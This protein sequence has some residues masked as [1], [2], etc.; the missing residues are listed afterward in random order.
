L[1][2][3]IRKITIN[4][5]IDDVIFKLVEKYSENCNVLAML[6][7]GSYAKGT[8]NSKSDLDLYIIQENIDDNVEFFYYL[9]FPVQ[10]QFR[11][12]ESFKEKILIHS[13]TL[14]LGC[15]AKVLFNRDEKKLDIYYYLSKSKELEKLGPKKL[16]K[17]QVEEFLICLS[18]DIVPIYGYI[19]KKDFLSARI[20]INQMI[21]KALN[22]LYDK[23]NYF[24]P[25]EKHLFE[26][27]KEKDINIYALAFDAICNHDLNFCFE[28]CKKLCEMILKEIGSK[29]DTYKIFY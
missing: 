1:E 4:P 11:N 18:N 28:N 22:L 7:I 19:E 13:R 9:N 5:Y 8:Y 25:G 10:I 6:L 12:I 2:D 20:Q 16:D 14:P 26:D 3:N 29:I 17:S 23:R 21:L 27:L 24:W 15:Y